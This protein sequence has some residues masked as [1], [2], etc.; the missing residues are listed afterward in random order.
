VKKEEEEEDYVNVDR[1]L[2]ECSGLVLFQ[3]AK[4]SICTEEAINTK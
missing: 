4:Y 3:Q 2:V 1:V